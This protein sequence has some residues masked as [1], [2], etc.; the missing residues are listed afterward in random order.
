[1]KPSLVVHGGGEVEVVGVVRGDSDLD[2]ARPLLHEAVD[3]DLE[4]LVVLERPVR[5][6]DAVVELVVGPPT[7]ASPVV[8]RARVIAI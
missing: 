6:D 8:F 1:M 7:L 2:A 4:E 3:A 5:H